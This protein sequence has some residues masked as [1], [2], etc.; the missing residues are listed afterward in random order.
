MTWILKEHHTPLRTAD[1][2][3]APKFNVFQPGH[4][5]LVGFLLSVDDVSPVTTLLNWKCR[6][7]RRV[8]LTE[9]LDVGN[10]SWNW[11]PLAL[12]VSM[13]V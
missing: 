1:T 5:A 4:P 2:A 8:P 12:P 10:L 6:A 11:V 3:V 7:R 13:G 9:L